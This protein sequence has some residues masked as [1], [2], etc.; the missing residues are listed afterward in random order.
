MFNDNDFFVQIKMSKKE[1]YPVSSHQPRRR[2]M[3]FTLKCARSH[4]FAPHLNGQ[5]DV[6]RE[7]TGP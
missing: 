4:F 2:I 3:S 6:I 5:T 7:N 1:P